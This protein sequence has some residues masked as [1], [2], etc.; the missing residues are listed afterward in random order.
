[1]TEVKQKAFE[2]YTE[3]YENTWAQGDEDRKANAKITSLILV[4]ELIQE[5]VYS[6]DGYCKGREDYWKE[7]KQEI[8]KL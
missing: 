4:D 5:S 8:S 6:D 2:I 1:M 3:M 7:V